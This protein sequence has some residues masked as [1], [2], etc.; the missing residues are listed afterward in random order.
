METIYYIYHIYRPEDEG[1][2]DKGYIGITK[3][4]S[5]RKSSH[6][7][8]LS[9]QKH[10]NPI[11]QS[12][13]NKDPNL[14][15][16]I[17]CITNAEHASYLENKLRPVQAMGWNICIGGAATKLGYKEPQWVKDKLKA[18]WSN[19]P[20]LKAAKEAKRFAAW[21][22][23]NDLKPKALK[24]KKIRNRTEEGKAL[25]KSWQDW[26]LNNPEA[27][28]K[29]RQKA[30]EARQANGFKIARRIRY[31]ADGIAYDR[32][33]DIM[34]KYNITH[35]I[36]RNRCYGI[37][38]THPYVNGKRTTKRCKY[39]DHPELIN[40]YPTWGVEKV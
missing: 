23:Q 8:L 29:A 33:E 11:L 25:Y 38:V 40:P 27:Y 34:E 30:L 7:S 35:A 20:E 19:N 6:F 2:Y 14:Q 17:I 16:K 22:I 28:Q 5:A 10:P 15:W 31:I 21:K 3:S 13:Y 24:I 4:P 1:Q 18:F 12:A 36:I 37:F 32:Y 26:K 39:S 9:Q